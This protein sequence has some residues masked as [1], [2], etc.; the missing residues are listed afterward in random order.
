MKK[1]KQA[2]GPHGRRGRSERPRTQL[3]LRSCSPFSAVLKVI[4]I[5]F[6]ACS[7]FPFPHFAHEVMISKKIIFTN[8]FPALKEMK[9]SPNKQAVTP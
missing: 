5:V 9:C 7:F 3:T 1:E 4:S 8:G 2:S 6:Y